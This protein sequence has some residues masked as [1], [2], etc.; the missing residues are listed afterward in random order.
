MTPDTEAKLVQLLSRLESLPDAVAAKA[1]AAGT[2]HLA[3][4]IALE[5]AK[6]DLLRRVEVLENAGQESKDASVAELREQLRRAQDT[7]THWSRYVVTALVAFV[8]GAGLLLL[9]KFVGK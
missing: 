2:E 6:A 4:L 8:T 5:N 3:R 7:T 9:G 1:V